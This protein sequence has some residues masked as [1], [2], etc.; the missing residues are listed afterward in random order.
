MEQIN[1]PIILGSNEA[2]LKCLFGYCETLYSCDTYQYTDYSKYDCNMF[3]A[4]RK[5]GQREKQFPVDL[6]NAYELGVRLAKK[7]KEEFAE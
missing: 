7:A 2:A 4:Q 1:Y 3:D 6:Q 5:A